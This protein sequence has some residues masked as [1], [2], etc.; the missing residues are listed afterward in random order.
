MKKSNLAVGLPRSIE[1]CLAVASLIALLPLLFLIALAI[2]FSDSRERI[3][4]LQKRVGA[5]GADFIIYKFR[6]MRPSQAGYPLVTAATDK[7]ITR[8]GRML[9]K[10]K[11]DELPELWNI[12]WGDMSFVGPRP[13]VP[14][15]VDFS[16]PL[17]KEILTARPGLTDPVTL[18]LRNEEKI[19]AAVADKEL[20]YREVLQP[21]KMR[22]YAKFMKKRSGRNDVKIICQT[23]KV[24]VFPHGAIS[25][26]LE[27]IRVS[28]A[29]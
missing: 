6:T 15:L 10:T 11:L 13:E 28:L 3:L 16:D 1:V 18:R 29:E 27:E 4:F 5:G 2:K 19:M 14:E 20:F 21:F 22:G 25:P 17:W 23:I 9:R 12:L 8:L 24:I 7:R 26:S